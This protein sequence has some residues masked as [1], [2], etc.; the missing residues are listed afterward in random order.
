M[1][2]IALIGFIVCA[3]CSVSFSQ[4]NASSTESLIV[5]GKGLGVISIGS[6]R[7]EVEKVI[8]D[9]EN[10]SKYDNVYF[11]DYPAKGIQISYA[12][13]TDKVH[14]VF[15]YNKQARYENF[16][17]ADVK[18]DKGVSWT[19]SPKDVLKAYGKPKD[20]FKDDDGGRNW[21]RI[22]F[23]GID[24][25]FENMRLVRIGVPAN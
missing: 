15:F 23:A 3:F 5:A 20:H 10:R 12:N 1:R 6:G 17:A 7:S 19:S 13:R 11:V 25:R 24:F 2:K 8:G 16:E 21:Q 9:G 14:A 4:N 22:V 18:T